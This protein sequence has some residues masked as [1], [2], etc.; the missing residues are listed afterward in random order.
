MTPQLSIVLIPLIVA[1]EDVKPNDGFCFFK[2]SYEQY[3]KKLCIPTGRISPSLQ[4]LMFV[5][6]KSGLFALEGE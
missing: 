4:K 2:L 6:T 3:T 5:P 1:R